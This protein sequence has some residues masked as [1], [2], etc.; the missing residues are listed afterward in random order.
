MFQPQPLLKQRI[1][2]LFIYR[3]AIPD[4]FS[5]RSG[6]EEK[7]EGRRLTGLHST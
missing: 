5:T 4:G 7:T 1:A 3:N 6:A 2:I